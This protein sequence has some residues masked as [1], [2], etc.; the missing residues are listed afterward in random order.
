MKRDDGSE[1]WA[2]TAKRYVDSSP[3]VVGKRV[4]VGST[5]GRLYGLNAETGDKEWEFEAGVEINSSPAVVDGYLVIADARGTVYCFG[6][7]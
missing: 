6:K 3:I 2:F 7:K 5:D 4:F 1:Q